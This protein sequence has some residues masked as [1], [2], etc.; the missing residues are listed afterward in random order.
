MIGR[1]AH[2]LEEQLRRVLRLHADLLEIAA[3]LET[4]AL[5]LDGDQRG[6]LGAERGIGLGDHDHEIG[7]L[8]V[9]DEGFG[10][11]D[12]PMVA[13]HHGRGLD[14][15]QV[16]ARARL[17][18]GD[19]RDQ[20]AGAGLGN[21]LLLLLLGAVVEQVGD[22]DVVVQR[23]GGTGGQRA[24]LLLD[25]DGAV[26]EIGAHA[27]I[28]L[29]HRHAQKPLLA[30]LAPQVARHDPLLLP[31]H[32]EGRHFLLEKAPAGVAEHL[33]FGRVV[34][35]QSSHERRPPTNRSVSLLEGTVG[36]LRTT[37]QRFGSSLP[38][39]KRQPTDPIVRGS[40]WCATAPWR[41]GSRP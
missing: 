28:G 13:V 15:L 25:H 40:L 20:F 35:G 27:A 21:P 29:R 10:A 5:R 32:V 31:L 33:V 37:R 26:E 8:A 18:H 12:D 9:R 7:E 34:R 36:R 23:E 41:L 39:R 17:G 30:G 6:A 16:G 14:R 24:S 1:H 19:G 38:L 22:H 2:V 11:V 4:F 3:A